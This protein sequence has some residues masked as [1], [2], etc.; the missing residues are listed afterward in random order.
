MAKTFMSLTN[1]MLSKKKKKEKP[2]RKEYMMHNS[3]FA[4]VKNWQN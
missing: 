1:I 3:I 2:D 4:K